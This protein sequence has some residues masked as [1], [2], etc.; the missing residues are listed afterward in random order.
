MNDYKI[1][2][3]SALSR[4]VGALQISIIII[5]QL[6]H[7]TLRVQIAR[8]THCMHVSSCK[9]KTCFARLRKRNKKQNKT[10]DNPP[11][12]TCFERIICF[13]VDSTIRA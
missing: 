7:E 10:A 6:P 3:Y 2:I 5:K 1:C 4:R 9:L 8:Y 11:G 13:E 12:K